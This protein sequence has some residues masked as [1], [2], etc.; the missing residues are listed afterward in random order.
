MPFSFVFDAHYR[1]SPKYIYILDYFSVDFL[2]RPHHFQIISIAVMKTMLACTF[3]EP[4]KT[5]PGDQ[6]VD[7]E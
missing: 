1:F 4:N 6:D 3:N 5:C 7:N 2:K